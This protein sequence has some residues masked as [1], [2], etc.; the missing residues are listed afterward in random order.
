M[1]SRRADNCGEPIDLRAARMKRQSGTA[2]QE[3]CRTEAQAD[4]ERE[5]EAV[6][7]RAC[8]VVLENS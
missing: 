2:Q 8:L 3:H 7:R 6:K 4:Y 5:L 1:A